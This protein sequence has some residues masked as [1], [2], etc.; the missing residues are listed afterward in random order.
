LLQSGDVLVTNDSKVIPARLFGKKETGGILE[1]LLLTRKKADEQSQTWEVLI[2]PAKRLHEGDRIDLYSAC[3]A[4]VTARISEKKWLLD[5][6]LPEAS[7][8]F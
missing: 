2:R 6:L 8:P 5:F 4:T 1:L 7:N 3:E